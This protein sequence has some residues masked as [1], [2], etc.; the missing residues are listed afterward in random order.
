[1][2]R[3]LEFEKEVVSINLFQLHSCLKERHSD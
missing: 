1:M 2:G 3:Q